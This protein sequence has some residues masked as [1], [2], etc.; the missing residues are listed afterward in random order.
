VV[1]AFVAVLGGAFQVTRSFKA[2]DKDVWRNAA[3]ASIAFV[4]W[5]ATVPNSGW[6]D[7]DVIADNPQWTVAVCGVFAFLFALFAPKR[8]P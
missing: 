7:V 8:N 3:L 2:F 4:I 1:L 5:S 6:Q